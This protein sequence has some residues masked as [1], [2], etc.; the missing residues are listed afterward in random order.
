MAGWKTA[1]SPSK[2][3]SSSSRVVKGRGVAISL[4]GGTYDA[5][6]AEVEVDRHTGKVRVTTV[7]G[8]QDNG[9]TVN[10][11][12]VVLGAEAAIVQATSRTLLEQ[13]TFSKSAITSLDWQSYPIITFE[14][15]PKVNF[16]LIDDWNYASSGSGEPPMTPTAA[17]IGNAVFDATGVRLRSL[18]FRADVVK[19]A[20]RA[21]AKAV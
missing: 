11:R 7:W 10:P 1:A 2:P 18:P 15:A 17:A 16:E 20:L 6:V 19:T 3:A 5:N 8:A 13:V 21:A 12:A 14:E 9:L 4:R